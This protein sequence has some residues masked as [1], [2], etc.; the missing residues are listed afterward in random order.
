M[1]SETPEYQVNGNIFIDCWCKGSVHIVLY[2]ILKI[3]IPVFYA[4]IKLLN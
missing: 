4:F 3:K 2:L 1:A